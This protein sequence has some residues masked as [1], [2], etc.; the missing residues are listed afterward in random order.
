MR[1]NLNF[2]DKKRLFLALLNLSILL[3]CSTKLYANTPKNKHYLTDFKGI[4]HN[5]RIK[6][7][8]II[9]MAVSSDVILFDL[10]KDEKKNRLIALSPFSKSKRFSPIYN[11]TQN[12]PHSV[13]NKLEKLIGLKPDLV[14]AASYTRV[15]IIETLK[16]ANLNVFVLGGFRSIENIRTNIKIL[17][18]LTHTSK[19]AKALLKNFNERIKGIKH[20][21]RT[22]KPLRV[23]NFS[24]NYTLWGK[25]TLFDEATKAA[26]LIN[27]ASEKGYQGWPQ[28]NLEILSTLKPDLIIAPGEKIDELHIIKRIQ[29]TP[30]WKHLNA[31]KNGKIIVIPERLLNTASHYIADL[32]E[33]IYEKS[34]N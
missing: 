11:K 13:G 12:I 22:K 17:G 3:L 21:A 25:E 1:M 4:I 20:E 19:R 18:Q 34:Y 28:I 27:L 24:N 8:R 6:P 2:R 7:K 5:T 23:L 29:S 16:A 14:I 9:S 33:T 26:G 30:G 10:L 15:E 31:V 32:T